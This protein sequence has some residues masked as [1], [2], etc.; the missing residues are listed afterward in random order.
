MWRNWRWLSVISL[1]LLMG[2][3]VAVAAEL[4]NRQIRLEPSENASA[5]AHPARDQATPAEQPGNKLLSLNSQDA[6]ASGILLQ[7]EGALREDDKTLNDGSL[8]DD[9]F[10]GGQIGQIIRIT[11]ESQI[12]DTYLLL[13][14]SA[15]ERVAEIDD[16]VV[17][18]STN[19]EIVVQLPATGKYRVFA[20]SFD[21]VGGGPYKLTIALATVDEL[22]QAE[23]KNEAA[24]KQGF[25]V[26]DKVTDEIEELEPFLQVEGTLE[27]GDSTLDNGS[28]YDEY[29]FE[30]E[31]GQT[32]TIKIEGLTLDTHLFLLNPAGNILEDFHD[33][34]SWDSQISVTLPE[35]GTYRVL[36]SAYYEQNWGEYILTISRQE[37]GLISSAIDLMQYDPIDLMR[38]GDLHYFRDE[39]EEALQ[40]YQAALANYW[41][42]GEEYRSEQL[43]ALGSIGH[44]YHSLGEYTQALKYYQQSLTIA[45]VQSNNR[46][47]R[48]EAISLGSIGDVYYSL[49]NYSK[50]LGYYQQ[51]LAISLALPDPEGEV[52]NLRSIGNIYSSLENYPQ[53]IDYFQQSLTLANDIDVTWLKAAPLSGLG[54][55]FAALGDYSQALNYFQQSLAIR[56][57]DGKRTGEASNLFSI[58]NVYEKLG[59]YSQALE[60]YQQSLAI[61]RDIGDPEIKANPLIH[62]GITRFHMGQLLEAEEMLFKAVALLELLRV[63]ELGDAINISQFELQ[64]STYGV[65]QQVLA[66][67]NQ[68]QRALEIAEQGRTRAFAE[69]LAKSFN[70]KAPDLAQIQQIAQRQN[71]TLVEYSVID[72]GVGNPQIYIWVVRPNGELH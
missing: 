27:S 31:A 46:R 65:L 45:R 3:M 69:L 14:D 7:V 15:G 4:E 55:V 41:E 70:S 52:V 30:G 16:D 29:P 28:V 43:R 50:A 47:T 17:G 35:N 32:I 21:K 8:Y 68:P 49:G 53:A 56:R 71:S 9:Y 6:E 25:G 67:R 54:D 40:H 38:V 60:Y 36:A 23:Q 5:I 57:D 37:S 62:I 58:G 59:D 44:V 51:A 13:D 39:Y 18:N 24:Q 10:F 33:Y 2:D 61:A 63:R 19:S 66:A 12:F 64:K 48:A 42:F 11:L 20:N 72:S 26:L 34:D 22:R 1:T